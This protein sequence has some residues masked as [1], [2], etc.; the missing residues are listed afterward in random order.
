MGRVALP[1]K[2]VKGAEAEP[3]DLIRHFGLATR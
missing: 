2:N 3:R 1:G